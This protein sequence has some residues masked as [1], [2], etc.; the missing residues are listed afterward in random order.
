MANDVRQPKPSPADPDLRMQAELEADP[1][2]KLSE[3]GKA[4]PLQIGAV[5]L[6]IIVVI[7]VVAWA[8][9]QNSAP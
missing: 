2:L 8:I 4:T 1:M 7:G 6:A 3:G 5:A 9:I